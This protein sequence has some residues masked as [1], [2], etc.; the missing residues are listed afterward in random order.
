ML[1]PI[2]KPDG[3]ALMTLICDHCR[4]PIRQAEYP[5]ATVDFTPATLE[6]LALMPV[7]QLQ[8]V[9]HFHLRCTPLRCSGTHWQKADH[10]LLAMVGGLFDEPGDSIGLTVSARRL[11]AMRPE[12]AFP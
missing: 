8:P 12:I 4:K 2:L 3:K 1:Y 6:R 10:V 9:R 7:D 11:Y 5:S